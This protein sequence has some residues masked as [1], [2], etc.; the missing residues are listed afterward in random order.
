MY[1]SNK[2]F[3]Y[4]L[5]YMFVTVTKYLAAVTKIS[6]YYRLYRFVMV[7]KYFDA[8]TKIP[9]Y[10]LLYMFGIVT[11]YCNCNKSGALSLYICHCTKSVTMQSLHAVFITLWPL[12]L[13]LN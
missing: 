11:K 4:F 13:L 6:Q 1:H 9:Q 2:A 7:T 10:Y 3:Q 8:V 12:S 5:L